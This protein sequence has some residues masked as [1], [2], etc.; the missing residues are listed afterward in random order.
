MPKTAVLKTQIAPDLKTEVEGVL[1]ELGK[2][3]TVQRSLLW[4]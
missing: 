4:K 2:N 1:K 3:K